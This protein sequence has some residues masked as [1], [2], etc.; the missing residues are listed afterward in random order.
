MGSKGSLAKVKMQAVWASA[1]LLVAGLFFIE[2][3]WAIVISFLILVVLSL[4][5]F[6][7]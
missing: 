5:V 2:N 4:S 7:M 3:E 6:F 1:A